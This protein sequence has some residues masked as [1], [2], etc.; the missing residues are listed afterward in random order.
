MAT[1]LCSSTAS[2]RRARYAGTSVPRFFGAAPLLANT[3]GSCSM[4][5]HRRS[6][7]ASSS[8]ANALVESSRKGV[9][10]RCSSSERLSYRAHISDSVEA[11]CRDASEKVT[12]ESPA[13]LVVDGDVIQ[14]EAR[15]LTDVESRRIVRCVTDNCSANARRL[16][17][18]ADS[19]RVRIIFHCRTISLCRP[20]GRLGTLA[21][22]GV[23]LS[24]ESST[25][26]VHGPT[27]G[28]HEMHNAQCTMR[29]AQASRL[30]ADGPLRNGSRRPTNS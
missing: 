10:A 22:S 7:G 13:A 25:G 20:R 18:R 19:S 8:F 9:P 11:A 30:K 29:K 23:L 17:P 14:H 6:G 27:A 26:I 21:T 1:R 2:A 16:L 5:R 28:F 12:L 3:A 24:R 4:Y 15:A